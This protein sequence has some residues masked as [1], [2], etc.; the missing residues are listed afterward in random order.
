MSP[1]SCN[2]ATWESVP[3]FRGKEGS[4]PH[5][6]SC[7]PGQGDGEQRIS[8]TLS[9]PPAS[10]FLCRLLLRLHGSSRSFWGFSDQVPNILS[11]LHALDPRFGG[12]RGPFQESQ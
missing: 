12:L 3:G 10:L 6:G 9:N 5:P 2:F 8:N 1:D 4:G 11:S 7:V